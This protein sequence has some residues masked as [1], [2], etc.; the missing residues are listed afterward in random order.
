MTDLRARLEAGLATRYSIE[1]EL[2]RGGMATVF[3]ARD[4]RHDRDVALKVLHPE[5]SH[6]LGPERFQ[7]EI[8]LA[9]RL[10]HPHILTVLDS[11]EV[12]SLLYFTMPYV[13]GESLRAKLDREKQLPLDDALR[14]A[15]EA[16]Q[17]LQYAHDHGVVHRDIKPENI[18]LTEDGSTLVADFGIARSLAA[19]DA[20]LT[21]TGMAIGTPAYMSPEQASGGQ[22]LTE[23]TDIYSLGAVLYEMLAGE[24]PF[25]GPTP[26]AV[27]ARRFSG[28]A[29]DVRR[30]R[31]TVPEPVAS[32]ITRALAVV[33]ADR[34]PTA[35]AFADAL[36]ASAVSTSSARTISSAPSA[37]PARRLPPALA[38]LLLG[39]LVGAGVLFA[40]RARGSAGTESGTRL[41]AVLPFENLGDT[42]DAYFTDGIT[43]EV[44]N[45]L[46]TVPGVEV[47][48]RG[49]STPYKGTTLTPARIAEELGVRYLL[50]G[51]V[52]R[53]KSG[54]GD[55]VLVRPELVEVADGAVPKAK[56]GESMGAPLTDVF[57]VQANIARQVAEALGVALGAEA[58][59]HVEERPTDNLAAYDAFLRGQALYNQ[60][61]APGPLREAI[62][63]YERAV[64]LDPEF[65][66]AWSRLSEARSLI[67]ANSTPTSELADGAR[68]AAERALRLAPD[69]AGGYVAM[70]AYLSVVHTDF[71]AEAKQY[72]AA[73]RFDPANA[74]LL[75]A[76]ALNLQSTGRWD[77]ALVLLRR[78]RA[79][80]PRSANLARHLGRTY[81]WLRRH[82][83]AEAEGIRAASLAPTSLP[84]VQF[85]AMVELARGDLGAARRKLAA[86]ASEIPATDI[87]AYMAW[88][89]DLYWVLDDEQ[90]DLLFRLEPAAFD[91]DAASR[92]M[93]F[94][95]A[96]RL[97]G[98]AIRAAAYADTSAREF[99]RQLARVPDDA[100]RHVLR[101]LMLAY[102]GRKAEAIEEGLRG[103][104]LSPLA[105]DGFGGVYF[106]HQLVRIYL[107][108]GEPQKALDQLEPLLAVPYYLTPRWLRI[109]PDFALLQGDPRFDKLIAGST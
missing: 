87:A 82:D 6:V 15:R 79:L 36:A 67:Y 53:I 25:T 62:G 70:G 12:G 31:T 73:L 55:Q 78:A 1:R 11:G 91:G 9:A 63:H 47:I 88:Y 86:A 16:A 104:A 95:Q 40:W 72:E 99:A 46:A 103:T 59:E 39:L 3:L 94:A 43:D 52:R 64:A 60:T 22:D 75:S 33:P 100:Q 97:R 2:G 51:T 21:E 38:M 108:V 34:F 76:S 83:E 44:R 107:A 35:R 7:R 19:G 58:R 57:E 69:R 13:A 81:L 105:N 101:G 98:D 41:I 32:A 92:A 109:D 90:T 42:S 84:I 54:A 61:N 8:R 28:E 23:R 18:L 27:I 49:S 17:A 106:Q 66:A 48:A 96:Y 89:W 29:P 14:I 68:E 50:T 26:Q 20:K 56:W 45:K 30:T 102:L 24:P 71:A 65:A 93:A 37:A 77:S 4:L 74:D 85:N 80:D 5:L 10:Q